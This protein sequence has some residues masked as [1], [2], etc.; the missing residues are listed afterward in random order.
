MPLSPARPTKSSA[1]RL[2]NPN[3][4]LWSTA[5]P[6]YRGSESLPAKPRALPEVTVETLVA[7]MQALDG[8]P[9]TGDAPRS[10]RPACSGRGG[11][12]HRLS[13]PSSRLSLLR[14]GEIRFGVRHD[15]LPREPSNSW[16]WNVHPVLGH[17]MLANIPST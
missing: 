5:Y 15:G 4:P 7:K 11:V 3:P 13:C 6:F 9:A 8:S 16:R 14:A 1:R 17:L 10:A 2:E 12:A